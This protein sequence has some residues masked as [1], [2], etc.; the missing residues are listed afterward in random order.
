MKLEF[1]VWPNT[2]V[3]DRKNK[4]LSILL[5][6]GKLISSQLQKHFEEFIFL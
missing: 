5:A 6:M 1:T 2:V 3:L 4:Y